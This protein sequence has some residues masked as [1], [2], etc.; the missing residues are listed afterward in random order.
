[1]PSQAPR[2]AHGNSGRA[3]G[4]ALAAR[5]G[6]GVDGAG[7]ARPCARTFALKE[8]APQN[9]KVWEA[10]ISGKPGPGKGAGAVGG[11]PADAADQIRAA[12]AK[13]EERVDT[14]GA[15][16]LGTEEF[17]G[18]ATAA[19]TLRA[20]AQK[21]LNDHWGRQLAFFN[22]PS[23]EDIAAIGDR[24]MSM[25]ERLARVEQILSRMAGP[26]LAAK[27]AGPARTRKPP[28]KA[29]A[30]AKPNAKSAS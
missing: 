19:S 24:L 7:G 27:R 12:I 8:C 15:A 9:I 6:I 5:P 23:R 28:P 25:D 10:R 3:P 4:L 20:R 29:A 2:S 1:M 26:D 30:P 22:M 14:I 21:G 18:V 13:L 16:L 17:A 11:K